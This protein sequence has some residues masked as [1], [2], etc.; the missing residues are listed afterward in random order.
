M[1][2]DKNIPDEEPPQGRNW[3]DEP[4]PQAEDLNAPWLSLSA[5][6]RLA[7]RIVKTDE[8]F[9]TLVRK[10][11][12]RYLADHRVM[13]NLRRRQREP[14]KQ[15]IVDIARSVFIH[16]LKQGKVRANGFHH[17]KRQRLPIPDEA[18]STRKIDLVGSALVPHDGHSKSFPAIT[19]RYQQ[20][21]RDC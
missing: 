19:D 4:P 14:F 18:W 10:T 8:R 20:S 13:E 15:A 16:L 7:V 3:W 1:T 5:A 9:L 2:P 12:E 11:E 17:D 21:R 6:P